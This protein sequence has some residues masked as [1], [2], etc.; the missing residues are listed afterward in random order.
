V[1]TDGALGL[2][3]WFPKWTDPIPMSSPL[4][5]GR[6]D[7]APGND[8]NV[9]V[10]GK[11]VDTSPNQSNAPR[12]PLNQGTQ[13]PWTGLPVSRAESTTETLDLRPLVRPPSPVP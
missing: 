10:A 9:A 4:R 1:T 8:S 3:A 7:T 12:L 6:R 2:R 11:D 5:R 13:Q